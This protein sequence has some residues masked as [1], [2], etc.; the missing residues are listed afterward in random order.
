MLQKKQT[1]DSWKESPQEKRRFTMKANIGIW[2]A[3]IMFAGT[4]GTTTARATSA[5]K[6]VL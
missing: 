3:A 2:A 5:S 6:A 4:F 1:G